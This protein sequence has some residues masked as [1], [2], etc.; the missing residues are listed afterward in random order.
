MS[1]DNYREGHAQKYTCNTLRPKSAYDP[2]PHVERTHIRVAHLLQ[3]V[4]ALYKNV[5]PE[6]LRLE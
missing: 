4:L 3:F 5:N 6:V 2:A 1:K